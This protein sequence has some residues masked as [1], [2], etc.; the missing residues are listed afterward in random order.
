MALH[1]LQNFKLKDLYEKTLLDE[2]AFEQ[3]LKTMRF[4][5]ASMRCRCGDLMVLENSSRDGLQWRCN[6]RVH[7]PKGQPQ[8]RPAKG[9]RVSDFAFFV[10]IFW[11]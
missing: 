8:V 5:P 9:L 6:R 4:V 11:F 1:E 3:W 2:A 7:R 10:L